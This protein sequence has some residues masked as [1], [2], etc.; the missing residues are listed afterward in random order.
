MNDEKLTELGALAAQAE[1]MEAAQDEGAANQ[2]SEQAK[3]GQPSVSNAQLLDGAFQLARD[4]GCIVFDLQ[5]PKAVMTD[6]TCGQLGA[7][8]GA[9]CDKKG[10][11]LAGVMGDYAAEVTAFVMTA[12]LIMK[13][14]RVVG[15][16]LAVKAEREAEKQRAA[17]S[18][19]V[20]NV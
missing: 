14:R 5:S 13:L 16:E 19:T 4:T 7:A 9:V 15:D 17:E 2:W 3:E 12:T 6:E 11:N 20:V 10:W 1:G 18:E 8:W